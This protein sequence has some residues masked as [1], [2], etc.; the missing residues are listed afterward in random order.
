MS[1][2]AAAAY[3]RCER[4]RWGDAEPGCP[5][6]GADRRYFLRPANG[7]SRRTHAGGRS[8][9]RVWKCAVCRRQFS[10]L[11]GTVLH[12]TKVPLPVWVAVA[13]DWVRDATVPS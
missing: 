10:V 9:R 11:T 6:C 2:D 5:H 13:D 8:A 12:A 1:G 4:L 7:R 3:E